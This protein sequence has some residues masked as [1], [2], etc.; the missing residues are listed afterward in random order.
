MTEERIALRDT[1]RLLL[2]RASDV[3]TAMESELGYDPALWKRLCAD[4]GVAALAIPERFGGLG[5]GIAETA[6]VLGELGRTLTPAPLLGTTVAVQALLASG[7]DDACA[8]LLPEIAAGRIATLVWSDAQGTWGHPPCVADG[9]R[10]TGQAHYVLDGDI[11]DTV[12]V[13]AL[14][15]PEI[16]LFEVRPDAPGLVRTSTPALD[17]TRGL[18]TVTVDSPAVRLG[19]DLTS[20]LPLIR[21]LACVAL[22]AEQVGAATHCLNETVAYSKERVQF[23]RPI[24]S[25]QALKHRMADL[26]V[27]VET[28]R[29]TAEAAAEADENTLPVLAAAARVHCTEAFQTVVAEMI[30]LHGGIAITWEHDAHLYFK[31][32]HGTARLFG[33]P[34]DH[35]ALFTSSRRDGT[36]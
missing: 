8:R 27:L 5:A 35:L 6:V 31:R 9:Q 17:P 4:I 25:F 12:L 33:G 11:A 19:G 18:T 2:S 13:F 34:R 32:A 10:V 20:A 16:G 28:A 26:H 24:G 7:D 29:A 36:R 22:S 30:Q 3:R 1:V 23:G 15:G 14:A 21:D